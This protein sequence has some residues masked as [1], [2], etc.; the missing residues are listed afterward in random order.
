MVSAGYV[1]GSSGLGIVLVD[2]MKY[3]RVWRGAA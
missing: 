2:F 1:G 3:A